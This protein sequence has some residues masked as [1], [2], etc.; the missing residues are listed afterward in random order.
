MSVLPADFREDIFVARLTFS[1]D[2]L[3]YVMAACQMVRELGVE[4]PTSEHIY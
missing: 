2:G 1:P 4:M 3:L